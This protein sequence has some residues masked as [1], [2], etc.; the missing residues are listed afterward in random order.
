M[1]LMGF[2]GIGATIINKILGG[3]VYETD[4]YSGL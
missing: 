3:V 4:E 1:L 2:I